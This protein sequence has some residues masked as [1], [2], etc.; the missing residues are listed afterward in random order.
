MTSNFK[1][2]M[3][4]GTAI[5]AVSSF[6]AQAQ[7][8]AVD[9]AGAS[10]Y[11]T[12]AP[13]DAPTAGIDINLNG[14]NLTIN[15][16]SNV[17]I[18]DITDTNVTPDGNIVV[19]TSAAADIAQTIGS[20]DNGTGNFTIVN[21]VNDGDIAVTVTNGFDI[22]GNVV[23]NGAGDATT[24]DAVSL[25]VGGNA[26]VAGTTGITAGA[27]AGGNATATV[28]LNGAENEFTGT[29]TVTGGAG[30]ATND[31]TLVITGADTTFTGGLTL[32]DG[33]A[34]QAILA[35]N[36]GTTAQTVNGNIGGTGDITV[37]NSAGVTFNG[38][39]GQGTNTVVI[40][41]AAANSAAT[42]TNTVN[43]A[44]ITLGG[45]GT[46][47]NTVTFATD[48]AAYTVTG[49][50]DGA[51]AGETN[52]VVVSGDDVVTQATAWGG[53]TG[54]ID[55]IAVNGTSTLDSDAAITADTITVASGATL[56]QGAGL[57]TADVTNNGTLLFSGVGNLTGDVTGTGALDVNAATTITGSITQA[58]AD[59]AAVTLTQTGTG[60]NVGTTNFSGAG[61]LALDDG[62]QTVAGNFTNTTAGQGTIT[63]ADGAGTTTFSG[64]LGEGAADQLLALTSGAGTD[65]TIVAN[66]N[67]HVATVT[68]DD[69]DT[70]TL[71]G[72]SAQ[73]VS[74]V[75]RG[76]A[77][78]DGVVRVGADDDSTAN[79]T[80]ASALGGAAALD[81]LI[82]GAGSTANFSQNV[83]L[84]HN[85]VTAGFDFNGTVNVD[86]RANT[87]TFDDATGI[88]SLDGTLNVNGD[89][90][91]TIGSDGT[92]HAGWNDTAA[93]LNAGDEIDAI[94]DIIVGDSAGDIY[95]INAV[96]RAADAANGDDGFNPTL[97]TVA[98]PL[99]DM[100]GND[101]TIAADS[102]L[103]LGTNGLNASAIE[104]DE[105]ITFIANAGGGT[106]FTQNVT[107][108][109]IVFMDTGF[110]N[111]ENDTTAVTGTTASQVVA[112]VR[113]RTADEVFGDD[114]AYAGAAD[115]LVGFPGATGELAVARNNL[116]LANGA[117]ARDVAESLSP[118]VDAG[119]AVGATTFVSRTTALA[120]TQLASLRDGTE[121]GAVAGNISNGLRAWGQVFGVTGDQ[122]ERD[123]VAGYDVDT[124]GGA[125]G[126][127][128]AGMAD[129][130]IV[131]LGFAYGNT[132]VDS[133]GVNNTQT[134]IDSY[135]VGLYT[136]YDV[137]DRTYFAG[138]VGYIWS[139][140]DQT[141]SNVG[142]I[143]G[144]TAEADYDSDVIF[145]NVE[146]GRNYNAG[147]SILTPKV[148]VNYQHYDA[149][150]YT[151]TGAGTANL[152][153]SGESMDLLEVGVGLDARWDFQQADGSFLQPKLGV[154]V[155]H[156]LIGDEYA[157]TSNFQGG[158]ASFETEGFD[159][160]Q[161][162]FNVGAGVT[163]YSTTNWELSAA[164]NYD[165][166][167]DYDAHSGTLRAGY[168]F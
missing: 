81:A 109:D 166:K 65:Q 10:T 157:T 143:A 160:A 134:D 136:S 28:T 167:S 15:N 96:F 70:L 100:N 141:R 55:N 62:T 152:I 155:R 149:D 119:A 153:T 2:L 35:M 108:G 106:N 17:A 139:D 71:N 97:T 89:N 126:I 31:A 120:S 82:V 79:V 150:G 142:G 145:A 127:D 168:K 137:D 42:F 95:T 60:Y 24:A 88:F 99:I 66:G 6:G 1:K 132:D 47:T 104:G 94:D 7:A 74:G 3:L 133:D 138:Q 50:V 161:T 54:T 59:I 56:D 128:T 125:I 110:I 43:V 101:F 113:L 68:L 5:V 52:N 91:F 84:D 147:T 151:E 72:T 98:D 87:V 57:I 21:T 102:T 165:V 163:Y 30:A 40:E 80:F 164:Y 14:E 112:T 159:P 4:A 45:A 162:T 67:V 49:T 48:G 135:Q 23:V 83:S 144:L 90:G 156:D 117:G 92:I 158:G 148:L 53:V 69:L 85:A 32:T 86:T 73:T 116:L 75:I 33:A 146:M 131:G 93:T 63:V 64:N 34:G 103:Q 25:T 115:A 77:A 46:G 13:V 76:A 154:G 12:T 122:D 36:G 9:L 38:T 16:T 26:V 18:G 29:V 8:Q 118:S 20:I 22:G 37:A 41:Q 44:S 11:G 78:G 114:D 124:V 19:T 61:T 107:D 58:S 51:I 129:G 130:W 121:T 111:L 105:T 140:N 39:V 123:G 27:N